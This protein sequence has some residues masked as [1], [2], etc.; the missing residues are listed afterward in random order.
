M[1]PRRANRSVEEFAGTKAA[2]ATDSKYIDPLADT[3]SCKRDIPLLEELQTNTIRV[4]AVDPTADHDQCM[5]MLD[6]AGIYVI[7][8]LSEPTL[9]INRDDP[10]WDDVLYARYTAV[11]DSLAKYDN[12]L[13]FFAGNEVSNLRNNTNASAFVKAAVRDTKAHIRDR[14]YR[15]MG[16]GYATNDDE[17]IR[18]S[19]PDYFN[20][21][22]PE[23]SI[24]FW[25]YNVY[26][27][28][29]DSDYKRSGYED[30]TEEFADYNVPVFFAEYGCN[31]VR[32]RS[33][34]DVQALYGDDMTK[35][36][37]GGII[38]MY[39]EEANKYGKG[40]RYC[41]LSKLLIHGVGLVSVDG[42][43]ASKLPDFTALS[44]EIAQV[45]PTGVNSDSYTPSNTQARECPPT[46]ANWNASST[47]PPTPNQEACSCMLKNLTC[48]AR[49]GLSDEKMADLF[50]VVCGKDQAACRGISKDGAT[51]EYGGVSMCN[52]LE[53][54][55]WAFN[56]YY[57]NQSPTNRA[58][59]CDFDGN[60]KAQTPASV[61][62]ECRPLLSQIGSAGTGTVTSAPKAGSGGG[63][64][65]GSGSGSSSTTSGAAGATT[66]PSLNVGIFQLGA[67]LVCAVLTG[68]GMI[69]L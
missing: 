37:S 43:S 20:C 49:P 64:R 30:R 48:V 26:S 68:A 11:V 12:V 41:S 9:S 56:A 67:Y 35:V 23:D 55:S 34:G 19:L 36:W 45:T 39:F 40:D 25:G 58:K 7:A 60:A 4:Y 32:P 15:K 38:Y 10:S 2:T 52:A 65:S 62:G 31:E 14:N 5:K 21:G 17:E 66:V 44:S 54:L 46:G 59:A 8:D 29:G 33:F 69:L 13:G 18:D 51:G 6:D 27:W 24:D 22:S 28:C 53:K 1:K 47:L 61:S 57:F 16:V 42:N 63:S 50:G 3:D